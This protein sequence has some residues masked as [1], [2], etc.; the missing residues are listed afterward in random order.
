MLIIL[1]VI[2]FIYDCIKFYW[3][4]YNNKISQPTQLTIME[5]MRIKMN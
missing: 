2:Y 5:Y 3:K 1:M 4:K